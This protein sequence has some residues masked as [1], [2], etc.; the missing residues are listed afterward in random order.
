MTIFQLNKHLHFET[1]RTSH[2]TKDNFDVDGDGGKTKETT[3]KWPLVLTGI[4]TITP[5]RKVLTSNSLQRTNFSLIGAPW[6]V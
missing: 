5:R 4:G 1:R 6:F 2:N 3:K